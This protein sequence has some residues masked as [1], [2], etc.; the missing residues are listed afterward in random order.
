MRHLYIVE[1]D[2]VGVLVAEITK[3][4]YDDCPVP[5][6]VIRRMASDI[7][8]A[9]LFD[10]AVLDEISDQILAT[11]AAVLDEIRTLLTAYLNTVCAPSEFHV[12]DD[13][14]SIAV[15]ML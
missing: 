10:P 12:L 9:V 4:Y 8:E 2:E 7:L 14:G 5:S 1:L 11:A 15:T 3:E 13:G 6:S